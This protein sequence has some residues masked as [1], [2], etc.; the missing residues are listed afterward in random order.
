[1]TS[2]IQVISITVITEVEDEV[3]VVED[4]TQFAKEVIVIKKKGKAIAIQ[5]NQRLVEYIKDAI[6][7]RCP[8]LI[9]IGWKGLVQIAVD[10]RNAKWL[11]T[12]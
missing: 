7:I 10:N 12:H 5:L 3:E 4:G 8:I 6:V 9:G 2:L 1:M 11:S